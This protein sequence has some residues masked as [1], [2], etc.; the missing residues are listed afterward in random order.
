VR[1]HPDIDRAHVGRVRLWVRIAALH[2]P[3][4]FVDDVI[5]LTLLAL[6]R[7]AAA[8]DAGIVPLFDGAIFI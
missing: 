5:L 6:E 2:G 7:D 1:A 8:A 4:G 3:G